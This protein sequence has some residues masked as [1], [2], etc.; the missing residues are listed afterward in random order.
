MENE[1]E[2]IS[3]DEEP[4]EREVLSDF[5]SD[6]D[7]PPKEESDLEKTIKELM[8]QLLKKVVIIV[9]RSQGTR[10]CFSHYS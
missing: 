5:S 9:T 7:Q 8:N 6:E 4:K 3:M 10:Y 1:N 2:K